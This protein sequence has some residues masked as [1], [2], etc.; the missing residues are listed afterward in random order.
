MKAY[1]DQ[2]RTD[3]QCYVFE[4]ETI[5]QPSPDN[6][7]INNRITDITDGRCYRES[8]SLKFDQLGLNAEEDVLL[9]LILNT[10]GVEVHSDSADSAW[11]IFATIAEIPASRRFM[12][13]KILNIALWAGQG[14][15]PNE[16]IFRYFQQQVD[17]INEGM[18]IK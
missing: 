4:G 18:L 2:Y 14:K 17:Y 8:H 11:P 15:L 7:R 16:A 5:F 3:N 6:Y 1:H 12:S 9:T 13:D 10:D